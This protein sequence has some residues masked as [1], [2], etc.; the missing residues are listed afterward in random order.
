MSLIKALMKGSVSS[1]EKE[2]KKGKDDVNSS[3]TD[4]KGHEMYPI[5]WCC[6]NDYLSLVELLVK[7]GA[8][9]NR[10]FI[11]DKN[12]KISVINWACEQNNG[13]LVEVLLQNGAIATCQTFDIAKRNN[14]YR[15]LDALAPQIRS[16]IIELYHSKT[17]QAYDSKM[18]DFSD[19]NLYSFAFDTGK[20]NFLAVRRRNKIVI[21][22]A[23]YLTSELMPVF[24]VTNEKYEEGRI[25]CDTLIEKIEEFKKNPGKVKKLFSTNSRAEPPDSFK[26]LTYLIRECFKDDVEKIISIKDK[27]LNDE[28]LINETIKYYKEKFDSAF[29]TKSNHVLRLLFRDDPIVEA[30]FITHPH[31]DHYS[32]LHDLHREFKVS[33]D[34]TK[35]FLSG[36]TEDWT[37]DIP[38]K[39]FKEIGQKSIEFIGHE[40]PSRDFSFLDDVRFKLWGQSK[41]EDIND[42]NQLSLIISLYF[43]N[44]KILFTGDAEGNVLKRLAIDKPVV[45]DKLTDQKDE[46]LKL[47]DDV[48]DIISKGRNDRKNVRTNIDTKVDNFLKKV[49][50]KNAQKK[51]KEYID[52]MLDIE[53]SLVVY[54]PHHGSMTENSHDIYN[55]LYEQDQKQ[56]FIISSFPGP[57]DFLPKEESV[58]MG[59]ENRHIKT[60]VHPIVFATEGNVP[61]MAMTTDPVYTTGSAPD[62]LYLIKIDKKGVSLLNLDKETPEWEKF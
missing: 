38:K 60:K 10:E 4:E 7:K 13:S 18:I 33:F 51:Y 56:V 14:A 62:D 54:E 49:N 9:P 48:S 22:D 2:I 25:A 12:E 27:T 43:N 40:Y 35:Y 5:T 11:N 32:L 50:D 30:V 16:A 58:C 19:G 47:V 24:N 20:A 23:G 8:N 53:N 31:T 55:Y 42:K 17:F 28:D 37:G 39:L 26:K 15:A 52:S 59:R 29:K 6:L 45:D 46:F 1:I 57:K 34:P 61:T 3:Y 44:I 36:L 41:P 21:I